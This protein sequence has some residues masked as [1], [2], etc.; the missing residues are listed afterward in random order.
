MYIYIYIYIY[1]HIYIYRQICIYIYKLI[2][3]FIYIYICKCVFSF[4]FRGTSIVS[5]L[6]SLSNETEIVMKSKRLD[7]LIN[8]DKPIFFFKID[9]EGAEINV[10][11]GFEFAFRKEKISHLVIELRNNKREVVDFLYN[12][13]LEC[14]EL[15]RYSNMPLSL[16]F[17]NRTGLLASH[18][19]NF[20]C[21][22]KKL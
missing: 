7:E 19:D 20:Y 15:I 12:F 13:D 2:Y 14:T 16:I 21:T 5:N 1:I 8:V 4:Y 9:A 6:K 22:K 18:H 11:R 10:L 17:Y 3:I